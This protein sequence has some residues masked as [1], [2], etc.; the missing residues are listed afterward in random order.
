MSVAVSRADVKSAT[1]EAVI[2]KADG[3]RVPL[4][5]IAAYHKNPIK[6]WAHNLYCWAKGM[7]R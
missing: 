2:I 6:R 3:T 4:G 1:V 5:V 7:M